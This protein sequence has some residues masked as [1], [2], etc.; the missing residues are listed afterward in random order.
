MLRS[1]TSGALFASDNPDS[2]EPKFESLLLESGIVS[3]AQLAHAH[4]ESERTHQPLA[5]VLIDL[6]L[7]PEKRFAE[8]I[9]HVSDTPLLEPIPEEAVAAVEQTVTRDVG[10]E[11][12]VVPLRQEGDVL[13]V[14]MV[15]PLDSEAIRILQTTT[16][17]TIFPV[18][19]VRS[20]IERLVNRF[21][22]ADHATAI[23][24]HPPRAFPAL[25][26]GSATFVRPV[27][28]RPLE[29]SVPDEIE[30]G[31]M[32]AKPKAKTV[33][34]DAPRGPKSSS[35]KS[36]PTDATNPTNPFVTLERRLNQMSKTLNKIQR[37]LDAMDKTLSELHRR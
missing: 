8:W 21:Y 12:Q 31:T 28:A 3:E 25:D 32:I 24:L 22:P 4:A 20:S 35:G 23:T 33:S 26:A 18:S 7:V 9:A 16:G 6:G 27:D 2:M 5:L 36:R 19:G 10:R 29:T 30:F 1:A 11:Y 34:A 14:V 17:L 37:R 15:N 13:H